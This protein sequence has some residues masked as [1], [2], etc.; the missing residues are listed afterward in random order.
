MLR[1]NFNKDAIR[2]SFDTRQSVYDVVI[3]FVLIRVCP[4]LLR[5]LRF[6]NVSLIVVGK[7]AHKWKHLQ[8]HLQ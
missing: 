1:Y 3:E 4:V 5:S 2:F 7:G 8:N 6:R